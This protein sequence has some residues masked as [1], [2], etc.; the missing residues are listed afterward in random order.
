MVIEAGKTL[1]LNKDQ[2]VRAAER[3]GIAIVGI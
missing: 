2:V 3:L 1:M